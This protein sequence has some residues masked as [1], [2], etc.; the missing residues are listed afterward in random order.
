MTPEPP[1]KVHYSFALSS[2]EALECYADILTL[3][4]KDEILNYQE[5]YFLGTER[6][7]ERQRQVKL[8]YG[9]HY[10]AYSGNRYHK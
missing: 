4:E 8:L 9:F 7:K 6:S 5:I 1:P 10:Q 2:K 3:E